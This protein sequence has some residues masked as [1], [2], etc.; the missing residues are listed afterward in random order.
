MIDKFFQWFHQRFALYNHPDGSVV[1][2]F[3]KMHV[4]Y[5]RAGLNAK[6]FPLLIEAD[7]TNLMAALQEAGERIR[8]FGVSFEEVSAGLASL[9]KSTAEGEDE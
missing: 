1:L 6:P 5:F 4:E 7:F 2:V 3:E 9:T 8:D